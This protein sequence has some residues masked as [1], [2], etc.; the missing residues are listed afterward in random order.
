[1]R[2][3]CLLGATGSIGDST[4]DVIRQHPERF[5]LYAVAAHSNWK[6]VAEIASKFQVTQLCM[7]ESSAAKNL[8]EAL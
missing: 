8:S 5:S 3:V 7:Y 6:K 4:I 1:M 2:K